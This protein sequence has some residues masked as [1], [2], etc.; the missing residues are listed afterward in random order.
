M[1]ETESADLAPLAGDNSLPDL[2]ARILAEHEAA[3][4]ANK[5]GLTHAINA[6]RLLI[7]AKAKLTH[8]RWLP[9]L[10]EHCRVPERTA[11]AYMQVARSFDDQ[12]LPT[13]TVDSPSPPQGPRPQA[14][15]RSGD[16]EAAKA[17]RVADLSFRNALQSL[18]A[19]RAQ[20]VQ[21]EIRHIR[22][23]DAR[24][25]FTRETTQALL[26]TL[27]KRKICVAR[28]AAKRQWMLAI[29]PNISRADL[30]ERERVARETAVVLELERQRG[31]LVDAALEAEAE[32]KRLRNEAGSLEKEIGAEVRKAVGPTEPLT[33]TYDFQADEETDAAIA[34]LSDEDRADRLIAA[35][36]AIDE[37]LEETER[38]YWGDLTLMSSQPIRPG[39][40]GPRSSG[41]TKSGSP[42]WLDEIFPDWNRAEPEGEAGFTGD[43]DE[44]ED[45]DEA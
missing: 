23:E 32:A 24:A 43:E 35:R 45:G 38:G 11:Q 19:D 27:G 13:P 5:R 34:A 14:A 44:D 30:K 25:R 7:E 33:V 20:F 4:A 42:E 17:Q 40:S 8:G 39:P 10:S 28:N 9:W 15:G 21:R 3:E 18:A 2:A 36:G 16:G 41:W 29:G 12:G 22:R 26:P 31:D 1:S 37:R 6:G